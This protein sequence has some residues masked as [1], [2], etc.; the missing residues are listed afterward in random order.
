MTAGHPDTVNSRTPLQCLLVGVDV[1]T[2]VLPKSQVGGLVMIGVSVGQIENGIRVGNCVGGLLGKAVVGIIVG[3]DV[4]AS[5][6]LLQ[7]GADLNCAD[8]GLCRLKY[9]TVEVSK[10]SMKQPFGYPP[11]VAAAFNVRPRA[12]AAA[13]HFSAVLIRSYPAGHWFVFLLPETYGPEMRGSI[14]CNPHP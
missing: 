3:D 1:G 12:S 11:R 4:G 6:D 10:Y 14:C 5:V 9:T 8:P 13:L 2:A 7:S